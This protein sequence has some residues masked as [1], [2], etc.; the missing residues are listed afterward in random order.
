MYLGE[1]SQE[2]V[3]VI[4][5]LKMGNWSSDYIICRLQLIN[6]LLRGYIDKLFMFYWFWKENHQNM[7]FNFHNAKSNSHNSRPTSWTKEN[8]SQYL[9]H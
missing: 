5:Q 6:Y 3:R 9:L 4:Q 2:S 8:H 7:D 1:A